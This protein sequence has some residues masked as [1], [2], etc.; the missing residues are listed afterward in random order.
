MRCLLAGWQASTEE[1]EERLIQ[2]GAMQWLDPREA[3]YLAGALYFDVRLL[4]RFWEQ[5][6]WSGGLT[7]CWPWRGAQYR[8]HNGQLRGIFK[9]YGRDGR[10]VNA[11]RAAWILVRHRIPKRQVLHCCPDGSNHNCCNPTHLYLGTPKENAADA[12]REGRSYQRGPRANTENAA[13]GQ[14]NGGAIL[15]D[16]KTE[17][18][19]ELAQ[20]GSF[21]QWELAK[22]FGISQSQVSRILS[23]RSRGSK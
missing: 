2:A 20:S 8:T 17:Q 22:K 21:Y 3:S 5:V 11:S 13:R 15:S 19:R 7:A 18:L 14:Y 1:R 6:D 23:G 4:D 16:I 10:R 12:R 9:F